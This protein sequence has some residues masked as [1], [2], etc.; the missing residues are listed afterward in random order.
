MQVE[1][2]STK[3]QYIKFIS[4]AWHDSNFQQNKASSDV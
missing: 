2:P 3:T 4:A 1:I